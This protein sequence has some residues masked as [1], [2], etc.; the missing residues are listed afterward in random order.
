MATRAGCAAYAATYVGVVDARG[1]AL[2]PLMEF[3]GWH[4]QGVLMDRT[5]DKV[6]VHVTDIITGSHRLLSGDGV[7]QEQARGYCDCPC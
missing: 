3:S 7:Q 4:L 1:K 5:D 2:G 6:R